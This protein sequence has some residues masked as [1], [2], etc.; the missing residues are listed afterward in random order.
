MAK[1]VLLLTLGCFF[2]SCSRG[3]TKSRVCS[4][5]DNFDA[6]KGCTK[7]IE[8]FSDAPETVVFSFVAKNGSSSLHKG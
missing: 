7:N 6:L 1:F 4:Y 5:G 2:V 3:I 8:V